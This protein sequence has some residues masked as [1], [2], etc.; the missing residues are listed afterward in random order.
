MPL[1]AS[2][3][4]VLVYKDLVLKTQDHSSIIAPKKTTW[5]IYQISWAICCYEKINIVAA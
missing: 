4:C 1:N 2:S 3:Q 5:N